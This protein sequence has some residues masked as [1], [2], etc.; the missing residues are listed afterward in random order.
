MTSPYMPGAIPWLDDDEPAP[1]LP[2]PIN[3]PTT[4]LTPRGHCAVAVIRLG[5][6]LR[7]LPRADRAYI[8]RLLRDLLEDVAQTA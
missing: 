4:V 3:R 6:E 7:E 2:A 1:T 8:V 5:Y